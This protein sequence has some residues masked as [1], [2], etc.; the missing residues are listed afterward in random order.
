MP[1]FAE[2]HGPVGGT[3]TRAQ[4][5]VQGSPGR[6]GAP[7]GGGSPGRGS[8]RGRAPGRHGPGSPAQQGHPLAVSLRTGEQLPALQLLNAGHVVAVPC[9]PHQGLQRLHG[10]AGGRGGAE[11]RGKV[12]LSSPGNLLST[13]PPAQPPPLGGG[14]ALRDP[15]NVP[16]TR[17]RK[18]RQLGHQGGGK[19]LQ[20]QV[21]GVSFCTAVTEGQDPCIRPESQM[22][23]KSF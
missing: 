2:D 22:Y 3:G 14:T 1:A 10:A 18:P 17:Y 16:Q 23:R 8:T 13:H 6:G 19:A 7:P 11:S 15:G 21:R 5:C 9:A 20:T 4:A 12:V